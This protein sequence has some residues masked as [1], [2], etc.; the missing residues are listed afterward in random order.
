[1]KEV[2]IYALQKSPT[3]RAR[4]LAT[5]DNRKERRREDEETRREKDR[6]NRVS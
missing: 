1:M 3:K 4:S 2:A 6:T 5:K